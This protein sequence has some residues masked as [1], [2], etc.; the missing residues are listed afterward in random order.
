MEV[1]KY[2]REQLYNLVWSEPMTKV[3]EKLHISD[4]GLK[5]R[6]K[7]YNIPTPG[8]GYWARI[9]AGQKIKIPRLPK[10]N[11]SV[12]IEF[13][14]YGIEETTGSVRKMIDDMLLFLSENKRKEIVDFCNLVVVPDEMKNPHELI[15]DTMQYYKSRKE[16]TKPPVNKVIYAHVSETNKDR[17]YRF[18]DTMLKA[19]EKLGFTFDIRG[20]GFYGADYRYRNY[21]KSVSNNIEENVLCICKGKDNVAVSIRE[22]EKRVLRI[23]SKAE[24]KQKEL[25]P[26]G[27]R[28]YDNVFNGNI[29]F[30]ICEES[31]KRQ[32]WRDT[33]KK[34]IEDNIGDI[35]I[36]IIDA[37]DAVK[38]KREEKEAEYARRVEEERIHRE[39]EARVKLENEKLKTLIKNANT[40]D[41]LLKIHQYIDFMEKKLQTLE[42]E[43]EKDK[44]KNY[45]EWAKDKAEWLNPLSNSVDELLGENGSE[46]LNNDPLPETKNN[47]YPNMTKDGFRRQ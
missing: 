1:K 2:T 32:C 33:S 30:Y 34:K 28:L 29:N 42:D 27:V 44:L 38:N 12:E 6:C 39:R 4:V 23:L 43:N 35:I 20:K 22:S 41:R 19:F 47:N 31:S 5:K 3:V 9:K 14:L 24:E 45:I 17:V 21:D 16:S 26:Q 40:Y 25:S 7:K 8:N 36:T 10:G 13:W 37:L 46:F 15:K 11:T 18:F